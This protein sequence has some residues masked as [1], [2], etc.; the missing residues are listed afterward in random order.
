MV[1]LW[2]LA[3]L[4][5]QAP[6]PS[7]SPCRR[8]SECSPGLECA[9]GRC[10]SACR[11]SRDCEATA[12]CLVEPATGLGV[13]STGDVDRCTSGADCPTG[14]LCV[15]GECLNACGDIVR[16]PDGV[17]LEGACATVRGDAGLAPVDAGVA[18]ASEDAGT[19][20]HGPGCD[21]VV[22][23][24][25]YDLRFF[26]VT[27]GGAVWAWGASG[28]GALGDGVVAH[29]GCAD[30]APTPVVVRGPNGQAAVDAVEVR[31][32]AF[33]ACVRTRAGG[34][35]ITD[36]VALAAGRGHACV[37]R[38][39]AREPWCWGQGG[40]GELG[41][42]MMHDSPDQAVRAT[43]LG[44]SVASIHCGDATTIAVLPDG[45]ARA[46]G[47]DECTL[48]G[49][50]TPSAHVVTAVPTPFLD[51]AALALGPWNVC[52][53]SSAG[54]LECI[55]YAD[56]RPSILGSTTTSFP[57][58]ADCC[59]GTDPCTA[60]PQIV[61][62]PAGTFVRI[63]D[64][65]STVFCGLTASGALSCWGNG[66]FQVSR[67]VPTDI[68]LPEPAPIVDAALD[69]TVCAATAPGDVYCLGYGAHGQL[70][71]GETIEY[72][73]YAARVVWP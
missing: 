65:A 14:L 63:F 38:G 4:A 11:E 26:A 43:E 50:A 1:A 29:G 60:A 42:G 62:Q 15:A 49:G 17:C 8:A 6:L 20:C 35:P 58:C 36:A 23:L 10:R 61:T 12:R 54:S 21:P 66:P 70:G 64:S 31:A 33:G 44:A 68:V 16:C 7:G 46:V 55:G 59:T 56:Y 2:A 69:E 34:A 47:V 27:A 9:L 48:L 40:G 32:G 22:Q 71:R 37:L 3:C 18:D 13:C 57:S 52:A 28:D 51:V 25:T 24:T 45:T 41:D 53:I 67:P 19:S 30:C 5:C 73:P 39:S 72:A